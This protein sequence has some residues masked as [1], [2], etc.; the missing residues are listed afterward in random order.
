MPAANQLEEG[1]MVVVPVAVNVADVI[2][3]WAATFIWN[4]AAPPTIPEDGTAV[5]GAVLT[6]AAV[7]G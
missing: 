1:T 5:V 2:A 4:V 3:V 7:A 6:M